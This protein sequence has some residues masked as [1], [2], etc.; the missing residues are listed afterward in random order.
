MKKLFSWLLAAMLLVSMLPTRA[1]GKLDIKQ[2]DELN[3]VAGDTAII[4][5]NGTAADVDV[6]VEV[7]DQAARMA[8]TTLHFTVPAGAT[9]EMPSSVYKMLPEKGNINLYRYNITASGGVK[10]TLYI[11]QR[12]T[13]YDSY[14]QPTYEQVRNARWQNNTASSFGPHFRDLTPGLTD[15]WYMFTPLDLTR[16][17]RQTYELVATNMWVIGE[18]YVDVQGDTVLITYHNYYDGKGGNTET[19]HEYLNIFG[20]YQDVV[21]PNDVPARSY[22]D[23]A[24]KFRFGV[25]FSIQYDLSGDT[26]VLMSVRNVVNYWRFPKPSNTEFRRFWENT[27]ENASLRQSMLLMMDPIALPPAI[28]VK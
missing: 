3:P 12:V 13:G 7:Y 15:L 4:F 6:S 5:T 20:S 10:K 19:D 24:T 14:N 22:I 28:P 26:N 11:A 1:A 2:V 25:P 17:G 27:D 21:I 9:Y 8:L 18:V 23:P 16:Q